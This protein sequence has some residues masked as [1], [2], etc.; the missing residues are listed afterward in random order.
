MDDYRFF[1]ALRENRPYFGPKFACQQGSTRRHI[2]MRALVELVAAERPPGPIEILEIGSWA[3]GSAITFGK[4]LEA[5]GR[6]GSVGC[7]DHWRPA[8]DP[9]VDRGWIYEEMHAGAVNGDIIRVFH[10]NIRATG[11]AERVLVFEGRS[12]DMLPRL[13]P[14]SFDIIFIDGSHAYQDVLHDIKAC[15]RLLVNGGVLCGDDLELNST[16]CDAETLARALVFGADFVVDPLSGGGFHPGVTAAVRDGLGHVSAWEGFW[17]TRLVNGAPA[18][19]DLD[20]AVTTI[21]EH[22]QPDEAIGDFDMMDSSETHNF[23]RVGD[24]YFAIARALG[25]VELLTEPIGAREIPPAVLIDDDVDRLR[26][27]VAAFARAQRPAVDVVGSRGAYTIVKAG[28]R[29]CAVAR[30]LGPVDLFLERIGERDL[31]PYI[32]V[33]DSVAALDRR[34]AALGGGG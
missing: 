16:E 26:T 8:F 11:L 10:H 6:A 9:T 13:R 22:L 30:S 34:L 18:S 32:L 12:R 25:V 15:R 7:V 14:A 21:P 3:G 5:T 29:Y 2:Y 31:P 28:S 23:V 24:R 20:P 1:R 33:D 17:A 19:V 4:A 27:R